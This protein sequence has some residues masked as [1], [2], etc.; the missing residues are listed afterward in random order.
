M[1]NVVIENSGT[2][3]ILHCSGSIVAGEETSTLFNAVESLKFSRVV[4]LDL[5]G[6]GAIDAR[7]LGALVAVKRWAQDVHV[8][9]QVV[10]SNVVQELLD[11]TRLSPEFELIFTEDFVVDPRETNG[12]GVAA[13]D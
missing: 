3:A 7:G 13:D 10:P 11:L 1:L 6:I 9:L 8:G 12:M 2:V 5:T 4:V